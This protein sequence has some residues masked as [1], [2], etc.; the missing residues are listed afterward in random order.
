MIRKCTREDVDDLK[1]ISRENIETTYSSKFWSNIMR[2]NNICYAGCNILEL[3]D[4]PT[5]YLMWRLHK[6]PR[7]EIRLYSLA[8]DSDHRREGHGAEI[9][10]ETINDLLECELP[11]TGKVRRSNTGARSLYQKCGLDEVDILHNYYSNGDDAV[12]LR[13]DKE[14]FRKKRCGI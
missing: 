2:S 6:R 8:I 3:D 11:I 5:G 13:L 7:K 4:S 14:E 10:Y 1:E 9:T 12:K